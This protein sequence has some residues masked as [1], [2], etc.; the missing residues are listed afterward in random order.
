MR[1]ADVFRAEMLKLGC[2]RMTWLMIAAQLVVSV[3][4]VTLV[5]VMRDTGGSI[6][7]RIPY[8]F[9]TSVT[10]G[11]LFA[12]AFGAI[13]FGWEYKSQTLPTILAREPNR[14]LVFAAKLLAIGV[15]VGVFALAG[16]VGG[17]LGVA[18]GSAIEG[19]TLAPG[20]LG[21]ASSAW[22]GGL[23]QA[24]LALTSGAA[25]TAAIAVLVRSTG[26]AIAIFLGFMFVVQS[27]LMLLLDRISENAASY[28]YPNALD[29]MTSL[30]N[31]S[32]DHPSLSFVTAL[33][34]VGLWT[35]ALLA[36]S[37]IVFARRDV[38]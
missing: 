17:A 13:A 6:D 10:L 5:I 29:S 22:F 25:V 35:G 15:I 19:G 3:V 37:Q 31:S 32:S 18:L 34:V 2:R 11:W 23:A 30:I 28:S 8:V 24:W 33:V 14:S 12:A 16:G 21:E 26:G 4:A 9:D 38:T 27:S 36:A 1:M 20:W 7:E